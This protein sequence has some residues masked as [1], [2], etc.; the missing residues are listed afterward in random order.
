MDCHSNVSLSSCLDHPIAI[1]LDLT[2]FP[3]ITTNQDGSATKSPRKV[4]V[5]LNS[6]K[7]AN[8]AINYGP[9]LSHVG[10]TI[11][12]DDNN[13][14]HLIRRDETGQTL[15]GRLFESYGVYDDRC[16]LSENP[17]HIGWVRLARK[18][19]MFSRSPRPLP[20]HIPSF[21]RPVA[22][23]FPSSYHWLS[24][25]SA[26][27]LQASTLWELS[28][29]VSLLCELETNFN[30]YNESTIIFEKTNQLLPLQDWLWSRK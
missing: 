12:P 16:F 24:L 13:E 30:F 10:V 15:G 25:I 28:I 20:S 4:P 17:A 6:E 26:L 7:L 1:E 21:P 2:F 5:L 14:N 23:S 27:F 11:I 8:R 9:Y 22:S 3:P 18:T 29:N 19:A